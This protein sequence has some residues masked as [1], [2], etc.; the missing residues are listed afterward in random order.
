[1][2][3]GGTGDN[4][5]FLKMHSSKHIQHTVSQSDT[6]IFFISQRQIHTPPGP[7][8]WLELEWEKKN[9]LGTNSNLSIHILK[10]IQSFWCNVKESPFSA[11]DDAFSTLTKLLLA[12]NQPLYFTLSADTICIVMKHMN[13]LHWSC[14]GHWQ[15]TDTKTS[16]HCGHE[17]KPLPHPQWAAR[18]AVLRK[19]K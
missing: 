19:I 4:G 8:A 18:K 11:T 12:V 5:Q 7:V 14:Q 6:I 15:P 2:W 16:L 9:V 10:L 17:A 3:Q 1:M 13:Y